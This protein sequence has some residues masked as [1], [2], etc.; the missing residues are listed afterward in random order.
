VGCGGE[1]RSM[2][3]DDA[4]ALWKLFEVESENPGKLVVFAL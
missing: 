1:G 2:V 4:P 3:N